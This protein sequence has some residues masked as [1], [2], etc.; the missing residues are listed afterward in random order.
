VHNT[1]LRAPLESWPR[2]PWFPWHRHGA[3]LARG[4]AE[5]YAAIA[6]GRTGVWSLLRMLPGVLR[7]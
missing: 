5:M 6:A 4:V 3:S 7:G 2:P 1:I